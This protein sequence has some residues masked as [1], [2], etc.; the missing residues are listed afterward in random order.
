MKK[1]R[2]MNILFYILGGL[3]IITLIIN[4]FFIIKKDNPSGSQLFNNSAYSVVEVKA[5]T[6]NVGESY[7]TAEFIKSDGTLVTN[8]HVVTYTKLGETYAF[9][10]ISIRFMTEEQFRVVKLEKY[11]SELDIAILKLIDLKCKFAPLNIGLSKEISVGDKVYAIGNLNNTGISMTKGIVSNANLNVKYDGKTR[12]VIQCDLV[13]ADGNSGGA[14][15]NERGELIGITT[16]R[17]KDTKGN[18][19]YGISY[20]VPIDAVLEYINNK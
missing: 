17:L 15:L 7:G 10:Q 5:E 8:A 20:C 2:S 16:F 13:I 19:I 11:N 18:V 3:F 12:N 9:E 6:E 4:L 14:L 1:E